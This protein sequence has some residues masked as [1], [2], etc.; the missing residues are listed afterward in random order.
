[1]LG[2]FHLPSLESQFVRVQGRVGRA[3][4]LQ[5]NPDGGHLAVGTTM[6]SWDA[7]FT[8]VFQTHAASRASLVNV[9]AYYDF[10]NAFYDGNT[11]GYKRIYADAASFFAQAS[12]GLYYSTVASGA[13]DSVI[14][15]WTQQF[16]VGEGGMLEARCGYLV[17]D[18]FVVTAVSTAGQT[19]TLDLANGAVQTI[20]T[21][22]SF[23]LNLAGPS[24]KAGFLMFYV[25][26]SAGTNKTLTIGT[27]A[28]GTIAALTLLT[29][30]TRV[31]RC[32][33]DGTRMTFEDFGGY[34][35]AGDL[36]PT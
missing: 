5:L 33:W 19:R 25:Y 24:G 11:G 12:G 31:Y 9:A 1:M 29:A 26:N 36:R 35:A 15:G 28:F 7:T 13:A 8:T 22:D 17:N 27:G 4:N 3:D 10:N 30:A 16:F 21:N 6:S 14:S 23:T 18:I 2:D 34:T 32:F 20:T